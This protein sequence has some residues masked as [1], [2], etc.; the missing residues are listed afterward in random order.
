MSDP[1]ALPADL[2]TAVAV[3][4]FLATYAVV[5]FGRAPGLRIDRAGAALLGA[6]LMFGSGV[7]SHD[8]VF[9]AIDFD[10][11]VL[12]LGMMIV[13]AHLKLSGFFQL[14]DVA[15]VRHARRPFTLLAVVAATSGGL[16][17]VL[18]N[19]TICLVL[20]PLVVAL[21][22]RLGRDPVPY[23]LAIATASNVGSVATITGNPQN[24]MI[25][26]LSGVPYG[27]FTAALGP[28]AL[29]GLVIVVAVIALSFPREFRS[30]DSLPTLAPMRSQVNKALVAKSIAVTLAT[31]VAFVAGQPV[32]KVAIIAGSL[33]LITRR[34]RPERIWREIDWPLLVMFAGLFVVTAGFRKVALTAE[35]LAAAG[36]VPLYDPLTLSLVTAAL[37]NIV[38]NVP[39]VLVLEPFVTALADPQRAWLVV[40]M[41][42]TLAGNLTL[43]GSVANLIVA[44]RARRLGVEIG[45]WTYLRVGAPVTV[46]TLAA[47]VL[48]A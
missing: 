39:A 21:A 46:A 12:L 29:I 4:I 40:A 9:A 26:S 1:G 10:T 27:A 11:I 28:V 8:E 35:V 23:A 6:S 24:M 47:G 17:A 20:T 30:G 41:A 48:L 42:A 13:V 45:F 34:L 5:A 36:H 25:G 2:K 44:E 33:L 16:S 15:I 43:V 19:D 37:S 22:L 14:V 31:I 32:A 38:S 7:L 18:V 3:A